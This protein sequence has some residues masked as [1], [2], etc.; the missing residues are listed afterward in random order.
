MTDV[1]ISDV[2]E[3]DTSQDVH[4]SYPHAIPSGIIMCITYIITV[5]KCIVNNFWLFRSLNQLGNYIIM[6]KVLF[7]VGV[8]ASLTTPL[9]FSQE[10]VYREL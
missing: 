5:N 2:T 6:S 8:S 4:I 1:V 9:S 3:G 7:C 10:L